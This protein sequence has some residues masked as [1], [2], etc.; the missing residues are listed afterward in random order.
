MIRAHPAFERERV[1]SKIKKFVCLE[2]TTLV[3]DLFA[4]KNRPWLEFW[5]CARKQE[6]SFGLFAAE[7]TTF[8]PLRDALVSKVPLRLMI[9]LL[10]FASSVVTGVLFD[11]LSSAYLPIVAASGQNRGKLE[12]A[13]WKLFTLRGSITV[14]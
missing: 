7:K 2:I 1:P 11:T 4:L 10:C 5:L 12:T 14:C 6:H 8:P 3:I 9:S 13:S